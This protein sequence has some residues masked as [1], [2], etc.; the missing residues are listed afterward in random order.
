[1][2]TG[3]RCW[4][5][6]DVCCGTFRKGPERV[7]GQRTDEAAVMFGVFLAAAINTVCLSAACDARRRRVN[8]PDQL[9]T[10]ADGTGRAGPGLMNPRYW[11]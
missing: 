11:T 4:R 8:T 3:S 7:Q 5:D 10:A 9:G 6:A 1:M 2:L